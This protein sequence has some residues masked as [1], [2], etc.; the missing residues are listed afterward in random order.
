MSDVIEHKTFLSGYRLILKPDRAR[1]L[2]QLYRPTPGPNGAK[3]I[4]PVMIANY[5]RQH[6]QAVNLLIE[7]FRGGQRVSLQ[8]RTPIVDPDANNEPVGRLIR[9][10]VPY[11][12]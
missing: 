10:D 1:Y 11:Q 4:E 2:F 3:W 8:M 12:G 5:E 6:L 9:I 7:A